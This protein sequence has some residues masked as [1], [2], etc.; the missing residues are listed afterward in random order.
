MV[1]PTFR[2][3]CLPGALIDT[4]EAWAREL[5]GDGEIALLPDRG[6]LQSV[7][8]V[9]HALGLVSVEV[10]RG[11]DSDERQQETVIAYADGLPL[12]WIGAAFGD[13]VSTW[14]RERG[15]MTL[16]VQ[17]TEP[18]SEQERKRIARFVA[19]LGRQSE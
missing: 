14:A 3:V 4:P 5:L 15:P 7:D 11:E 2:L 17:A 9:A 12:V 10:L 6:G 19:T 8:R 16:L 1:E 18:L 13:R